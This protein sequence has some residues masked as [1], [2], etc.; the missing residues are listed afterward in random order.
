MRIYLMHVAPGYARDIE[1]E[2]TRWELS[3]SWV[4]FSYF[5]SFFV[6]YVLYGWVKY[7]CCSSIFV[8]V[9]FSLF[10]HPSFSF[11]LT[12]REILL[13]VY[14]VVYCTITS[15]FSRGNKRNT[16]DI[17]IIIVII[18]FD[19][20]QKTNLVNEHT[21]FL[22]SSYNMNHEREDN[23]EEVRLISVFQIFSK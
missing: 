12:V 11:S 22:L 4:I 9:Y 8:V 18:D 23:E 19:R 2:R 1:R 7:V 3:I 10:I 5:F 14:L 20:K 13:L 21:F 16:K 17:F 6:F 15:I